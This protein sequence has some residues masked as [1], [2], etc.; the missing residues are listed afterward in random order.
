MLLRSTGRNMVEMF[1]RGIL[2][3]IFDHIY[4]KWAQKMFTFLRSILYI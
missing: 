3:F 1:L 4:F 2:I